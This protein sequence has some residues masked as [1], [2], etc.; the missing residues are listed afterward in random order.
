MSQLKSAF[1]LNL[2][3]LKSAI[4]LNSDDPNLADL[5]KMHPANATS[6]QNWEFSKSACPSKL[7]HLNIAVSLKQ[8]SLKFADFLKLQELHVDISNFALGNSANPSNLAFSKVRDLFEF[9]LRKLASFLNLNSNKSLTFENARFDIGFADFVKFDIST[10]SSCNFKKSA[11]FN[12]ACFKDTAIF[13]WAKD[14]QILKIPNFGV[15]F[16]LPDASL[17]NQPNSGHLNLKK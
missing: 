1:S 17:I 15:I 6:F 10:W 11:N 8:A 5:L 13:R 7:A 4:F 9:R 12:D 3:S 16:T 2:A 14:R